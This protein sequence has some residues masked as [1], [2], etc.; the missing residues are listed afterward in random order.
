[1]ITSGGWVYTH[2]MNEQL[3]EVIIDKDKKINQKSTE[4]A[5]LENVI[6]IK[7]EELDADKQVI[8]KQKDQLQNDKEDINKLKKKI[9]EQQKQLKQKDRVIANF[10][11]KKKGSDVQRQP[12]VSRS[13]PNAHKTINVVA[14]AYIALCDTGCTGITATGLNVMNTASKNVIAVDPSVIP[15]HSKVKV[16]LPNGETFY[17]VAEDTGGD[18]KGGR[19][20]ILMAT[21]SEAV[22]FGRQN[23][24]V[25]ILK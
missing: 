4:I 13:K 16:S 21:H 1:M 10:K 22:S 24:V 17:A 15:L 20:D 25:T 11:E 18:I 14:T 2:D 9:E 8:E 6:V 23:A 5:K 3:V 7:D 12:M 19:I